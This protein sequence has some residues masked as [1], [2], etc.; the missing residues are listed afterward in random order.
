MGVK[1]RSPSSGSLPTVPVPRLF[2]ALG[3]SLSGLADALRTERS[4]QLEAALLAASLPVSFLLTPNHVR[5]A[6][7]VGCLLAVLAIEL[8]NTGVEKLCD[9]ITT[10]FDPAIKS[11]KDMGSAAVFCALCMAGLFWIATA[12]ERFA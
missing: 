8:L 10:E 9:R 1:F 3:A 7:L 11:I 6:E 12:L 5:R 2:R 4:F